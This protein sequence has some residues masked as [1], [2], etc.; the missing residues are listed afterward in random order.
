VRVFPVF[1]SPF[2]LN[3]QALCLRDA[4]FNLFPIAPPIT[5]L[6]ASTNSNLP[7]FLISPICL[8][9]C[10]FTLLVMVFLRMFKSTHLSLSWFLNMQ[11]FQSLAEIL[12]FYARTLLISM[13]NLLATLF[14]HPLVELSVIERGGRYSPLFFHCFLSLFFL[15]SEPQCSFPYPVV[16]LYLY[17]LD[18]IHANPFQF[19]ILLYK[20]KSTDLILFGLLPSTVDHAQKTLLSPPLNM[21]KKSRSSPMRYSLPAN[22]QSRSVQPSRVSF[23][24]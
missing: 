6:S 24:F 1:T 10:F 2:P 3:V 15:T 23:L 17:T 7:L 18:F 8:S 19:V 20:C 4:L 21:F 9:C 11:L 16:W 13:E 5:R 22:V 12:F 14:D